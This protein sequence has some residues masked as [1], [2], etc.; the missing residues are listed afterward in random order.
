MVPRT[1]R[2]LGLLLL[3][4][5]I[6]TTVLYFLEIN[7]EFLNWMGNWGHNVAWGIRGGAIVLGL[8]LMSMGG[9]GGDKKKH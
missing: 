2:A 8:L 3:V 6:A 9:K 4:F 7:V 5:G 1:M